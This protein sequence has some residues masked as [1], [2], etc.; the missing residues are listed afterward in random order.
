MPIP[1]Q[2]ILEHKRTHF[3]EVG[4]ILYIEVRHNAPKLLPKE[5]KELRAFCDF[6]KSA[7]FKPTIER[8]TGA[9]PG[10]TLGIEILSSAKGEDPP[11][12]LFDAGVF[13]IGIEV[14]EFPPDTTALH[15]A[16]AEI[17]GPSSIPHFHET[18]GS[19]E[20]IKSHMQTPESLVEPRFSSLNDEVIAL[21]TCAKLVIE[22][23]DATGRSQILLLY[24]AMFSYPTNEVVAALV[25][26]CSLKHLKA[27][28]LVMQSESFVHFCPVG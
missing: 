9:V 26:N 24:G 27:V 25:A 14:T 12:I 10:D 20:L 5:R 11:D 23:K 22:A 16:I 2:V 1:V 7:V 18:G 28:V 17:E 4:D 13:K 8:L 19:P 3:E 21:C 6:A 15:Q